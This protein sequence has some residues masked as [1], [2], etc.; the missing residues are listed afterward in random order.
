MRQS[1]NDVDGE[2]DEESA[3]GGVDGA[4]E[5]ED[6][7]QEPDGD[8]HGKPGEG[9]Q[10]DALGVVHSDRLLPHEVQ[11]GAGEAEG[12]ELVDQHQDD[13]G[14]PP[15]RLGQQREGVGVRQKLVAEGPV[16]G[17]RRRQRQGEHVHRGQQVLSFSGRSPSEHHPADWTPTATP[18]FCDRHLRTP[19]PASDE[20]SEQDGARWRKASTHTVTAWPP[21]V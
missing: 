9:A 17:G 6:D 10:A 19:T 15:P 2:A 20:S 21:K 5:G 1:G 8:D 16:G 12:D 14:V 13:G 3:H 7:G 18:S 4:E 11:R